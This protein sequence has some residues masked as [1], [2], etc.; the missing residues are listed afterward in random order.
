MDWTFP[1]LAAIAGSIAGLVIYFWI[2]GR[3]SRTPRVTPGES[4]EAVSE[5][6]VQ[7][8][9]VDTLT[10]SDLDLPQISIEPHELVEQI[11]EEQRQQLDQSGEYPPIGMDQAQA[12][13]QQE[14]RKR[15]KPI[16]GWEASQS[17]NQVRAGEAKARV[18]TC[19]ETRYHLLEKTDGMGIGYRGPKRVWGS[20]RGRA[21][22]SGP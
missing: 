12:E 11:Q 13:T 20:L 16:K 15:V 18:D 2:R 9:H 10:P 6:T 17:D 5:Q 4:E 22:W 19:S 21:G 3:Y 1:I 8:D 7:S 14:E